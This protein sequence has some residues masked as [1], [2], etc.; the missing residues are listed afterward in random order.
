VRV[1]VTAIETTWVRARSDGKF[2]FSVTLDANQTRTVE[3]SESVELLLGNAGGVSVLLN[4]K[5]VGPLG[6]KGQ[7]RTLQF[8]SGGFKAV[9]VKAPAPDPL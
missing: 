2:A 5:P 6:P 8:N 9:S 1:Q 7:V 4:G 3:A